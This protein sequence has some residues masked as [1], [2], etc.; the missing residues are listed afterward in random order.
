MVQRIC[1]LFFLPLLAILSSCS[2]LP[3][4]LTIR[5][6]TETLRE[7]PLKQASAPLL[8]RQANIVVIIAEQA[9]AD[10]RDLPNE[11]SQ[12]GVWNEDQIVSNGIAIYVSFEPRYSEIRVGSQ[13]ADLLPPNTL[14]TIRTTTLNPELRADQLETGVSATLIMLNEALVAAENTNRL[15]IG[16]SFGI[17]LLIILATTVGRPWIDALWALTPQ[18]K[19]AAA[20]QAARDHAYRQSLVE[21]QINYA[22]NTFDDNRTVLIEAEVKMLSIYRNALK[23]RWS[24]LAN[25]VGGIPNDQLSQIEQDAR[26]LQAKLK[27]YVDMAR[28]GDRATRTIAEARAAL[29]QQPISKT[30]KRKKKSAPPAATLPPA[31]ASAGIIAGLAELDTLE[32]QRIVLFQRRADPKLEN[33]FSEELTNAFRALTEQAAI[34]WRRERPESYNAAQRRNQSKTA[35]SSSS[36]SWSSSSSGIATSSSSSSSSSD[37]G[38]DQSSSSSSSRDSSDGGSW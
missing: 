21:N 30:N 6:A 34:I 23:E 24:A 7:A 33:A 14:R 32:Q 3:S 25:Q 29:L 11:L 8:A 4:G 22:I 26:D 37:S 13:W 16:G 38:Y 12:L 31:N 9:A 5:D 27:R 15:I 2:P 19:A 1:W 36:D 10:G 20:K 17:V 18:A 35:S 28:A